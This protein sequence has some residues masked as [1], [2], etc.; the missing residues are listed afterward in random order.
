MVNMKDSAKEVVPAGSREEAWAILQKRIDSRTAKGF[1]LSWQVADGYNVVLGLTRIEN[2]VECHYVEYWKVAT[3]HFPPVKSGGCCKQCKGTGYWGGNA[4]G[5]ICY[6]CGGSADNKNP[7][8]SPIF[9]AI[10]T[11]HKANKALL[12]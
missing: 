10:Q 2:G 5:A 4:N 7:L 9:L 6:A 12:K 3:S 8:Q 11:S 1:T